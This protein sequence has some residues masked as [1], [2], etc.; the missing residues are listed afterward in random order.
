MRYVSNTIIPN[1]SQNYFPR[2]QKKISPFVYPK[3]RYT[4][5]NV[6]TYWTLQGRIFILWGEKRYGYFQEYKNI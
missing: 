5:L 2:T 6:I 1:E 4:L 3:K